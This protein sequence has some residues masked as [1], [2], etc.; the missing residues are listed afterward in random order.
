V[1]SISG[2]CPTHDRPA[3]AACARCGTFCCDL[4]TGRLSGKLYCHLCVAPVRPVD[5]E[6]DALGTARLVATVGLFIPGLAAIAWWIAFRLWR[7]KGRL[8]GPALRAQ[9][10]ALVTLALSTWFWWGSFQA[11]RRMLAND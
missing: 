4:C 10:F 3:R 8:T 1:L 2:I 5:P 11:F 6:R 9:L 7:Q